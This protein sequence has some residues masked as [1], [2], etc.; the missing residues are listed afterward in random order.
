MRFGGWH[1]NR[2]VVYIIPAVVFLIVAA[3]LDKLYISPDIQIPL[4]TGLIV[5]V[6]AMIILSIPLIAYY[7]RG[8]NYLEAHVPQR[9]EPIDLP[10]RGGRIEEI[11]INGSRRDGSFTEEDIERI[12][13]GELIPRYELTLFLT[14]EKDFSDLFPDLVRLGVESV[15]KIRLDYHLHFHDRFDLTTGAIVVRKGVPLYHPHAEEVNLIPVRLDYENGIYYPVLEV[16]FT[17]KGDY[18]I[19]NNPVV[20]DIAFAV[21]VGI[22]KGLPPDKIVAAWG[23]T[24]KRVLEE[25][26]VQA[27]AQRRAHS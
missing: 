5:S 14:E 1:R 4:I 6:F 16:L 21:A 22:Q 2:T 26:I 9:D 18:D 7:A 19:L 23:E 15:T 8:D 12:S 25:N 10:F 20:M 13:T 27:R 24:F 3:I 11:P 17:R